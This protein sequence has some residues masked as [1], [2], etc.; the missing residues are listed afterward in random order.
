MQIHLKKGEKVFLNGAVIKAAQRCSIEL[1]NNVTF[2]LETHVMQAEEATTP[3]RQLYFV[4][5]TML[6]E[7]ENGGLTRE[8]YWHQSACLMATLADR[9]LIAGLNAADASIKAGRNFDALKTI[10]RLLPT[11]NSLMFDELKKE[12]A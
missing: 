5:Q 6:I 3:L 12:V 11:E 4:V 7:P 2:L 9:D 8:L 1:L 10:R